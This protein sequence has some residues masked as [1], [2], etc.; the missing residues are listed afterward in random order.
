MTSKVNHQ[1][2]CRSAIGCPRRPGTSSI[3]V[4][5]AFTLLSTALSLSLPLVVR[6]GRLLESCRHYRLALDEL[7][8][9]LDRLTALPES[10]A[11]VALKQLKP[12]PFIAAHLPDA[13]LTGQL[14]P[15]DIGSR[16]TLRLSWDDI[17]QRP[18]TVAMAAWILPAVT[19]HSRSNPGGL[20]P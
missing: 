11:Q 14:Q 12:S 13:E 6:H 20:K 9:Q 18:T 1:R 4:L 19:P 7:S 10:D 3:E 17:P 16:L 2:S 5:V 8:N 15:A